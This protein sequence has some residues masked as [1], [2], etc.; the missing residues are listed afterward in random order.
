[1]IDADYVK[2]L[3]ITQASV[4]KKSSRSVSFSRILNVAI[5]FGLKKSRKNFLDEFLNETHSS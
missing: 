1:M 4:M 2:M 5:K 3:R